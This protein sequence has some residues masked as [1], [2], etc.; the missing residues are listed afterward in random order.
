[1]QVYKITEL[2]FGYLLQGTTNL[3][4]YNLSITW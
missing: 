3:D 2:E 1:M 4:E